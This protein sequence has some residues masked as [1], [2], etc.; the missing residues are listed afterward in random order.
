MKPLC[1][2]MTPMKMTTIDQKPITS[3]YLFPEQPSIDHSAL[4]EA[5][6]EPALSFINKP[7]EH[8]AGHLT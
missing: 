8:I 4:A 2:F 6:Y 3:T 7:A 5:V 1:I